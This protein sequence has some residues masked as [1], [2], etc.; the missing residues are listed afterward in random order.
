M[1]GATSVM[2]EER[3]AFLKDPAREQDAVGRAAAAI[4]QADVL[5]LCTGAGWSA[6]SG[7]KVYQDIADIGAYHDKGLTYRDICCPSY[8][9]DDPETF[10]GCATPPSLPAVGLPCSVRL[11]PAH[12]QTRACPASSVWI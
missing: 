10:Y 11:P 2:T 7:L 5:L 12:T 1:G 9:H 6:D 8:L 3:E 4:A